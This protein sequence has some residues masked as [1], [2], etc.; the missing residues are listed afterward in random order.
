MREKEGKFYVIGL[1]DVAVD[2]AGVPLQ[3]MDPYQDIEET[4]YR[5]DFFLS[6]IALD[7][8]RASSHGVEFDYQGYQTLSEL[9]GSSGENGGIDLPTDDPEELKL[10]FKKIARKILL[11]LVE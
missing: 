8:I 10:L 11:K 9:Q 5:K 6:R 2:G 7:I 3:I 4:F 1:G